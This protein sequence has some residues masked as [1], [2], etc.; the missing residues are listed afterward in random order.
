MDYKNYTKIEEKDDLASLFDDI[1]EKI[2]EAIK[3]HAS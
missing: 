2:V 1:T 3:K